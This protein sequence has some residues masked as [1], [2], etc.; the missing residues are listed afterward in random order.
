MIKEKELEIM[1]TRRN[2]SY[3]K[4]LGYNTH[5]INEKIFVNI[6]DVNKN[7]HQYITAI[8]DICGSETTLM[9][10]KYYRNFNRQNYYGCK[11]CSRL[12][13]RNTCNATFGFDN[14][15]KDSDIKMKV[16]NSNILK[17]GVKSTL[18]DPKTLVKIKNTKINKYGSAEVLS[19][20]DIR[21][22]GKITLLKKYGVDHY[23]KSKEFNI[24][25]FD[26]WKHDTVKRLIDKNIQNYIIKNDK[27]ID[28]YCDKCQQYY[29]ITYKN[30]YQRMMN[31]H[32]LCTLCNPMK[33][34][35]SGKELQLLEF[36][37]NNY[38][39]VIIRNEKIIK[40]YEIDIY[41]PEINLG[42]EFNG[43]YWHS[44][45][46][47]DK[48]YH[49]MK[50]DMCND[51]GLQLIHIWESD[52]IFKE[53]IIKSMLLNKLKKNP[54]K[55]Y[56][57]KCE[58][59][60]ITDNN[61]IKVFLE[62][63]HLQGFINSSIKLGLFH[64]NEL[65]SL[66]IFGK[67]RFAKQKKYGEYEMLRF[68]NKKYTNVVGGSSKLFKFFLIEYKPEGIISYA[69]RSY[70]NGGLYETLGFTKQKN[71]VPGYSYYNSNLEKFNRFVFRKS[72]LIKKGYDI[73]KTEDEIMNELGYFRVYN[74]GNLKYI[75]S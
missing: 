55:I 68:C 36:I 24:Q 11:K 22:K 16:E 46:Y 63:N 27:T 50:S 28:I 30:I 59:K 41:L 58:I 66:M 39:G 13:F 32:T 67:K 5:K 73:N 8:C 44:D 10:H 48:N 17:Y 70:S 54:N 34:G 45:L 38:D 42:I 52:W 1:I 19:C 7:S 51:I 69:D 57:R 64:N 21:N 23:S 62:D 2:V 3:Y 4:K 37:E 49:K 35:F 74:S 31:N 20:N 18:L 53:D 33:C 61:L 6:A 15:M 65:V 12:K 60:N 75:Y 9:I 56:A 14:P 29:N 72:E 40:P 71:S 47:K 26:I 43:I 25:M